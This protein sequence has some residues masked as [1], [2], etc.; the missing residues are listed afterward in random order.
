MSDINDQYDPYFQCYNAVKSDPLYYYCGE[1]TTIK[2]I[3]QS[4]IYSDNCLSGMKILDL[5]CGS[6]RTIAHLFE[7]GASE[8]VGL[9]LSPHMVED[10]IRFLTEIGIP[11]DKFLIKQANCFSSAELYNALPLEQYSEH[12]DAITA[13]YLHCYA[14][15]LDKLTESFLVSNKWLKRDGVLCFTAPNPKIATEFEYFQELAETRNF[16]LQFK[17]LTHSKEQIPKEKLAFNNLETGKELFSVSTFLYQIN[18]FREALNRGGFEL[19]SAKGLEMNPNSGLN[20]D[21]D[22]NILRVGEYSDG[23][24]FKAK[25]NSI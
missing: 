3:S 22:R 10:A 24:S 15:N 7:K 11:Q 6:G 18:H 12:F 9:D 4:G 14:E 17:S 23:Y 20:L 2:E 25:N 8:A 16:F 13:Q 19:I 5:G 1:Y 21:D